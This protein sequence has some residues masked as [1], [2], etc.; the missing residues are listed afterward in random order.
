MLE[1]RVNFPLDDNEI[2]RIFN[3]L[4]LKHDT[5]HSMVFGKYYDDDFMLDEKL[6][7]ILSADTYQMSVVFMV[8]VWI[9]S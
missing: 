4:R 1:V 7:G 3:A 2:E 9:P 5:T 8:L 6:L